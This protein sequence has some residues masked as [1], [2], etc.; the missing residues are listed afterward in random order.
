MMMVV[1]YVAKRNEKP[2]L[3]EIYAAK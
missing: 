1:I 2:E 3:K